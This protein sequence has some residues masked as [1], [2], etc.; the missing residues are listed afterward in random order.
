MKSWIYSAP[1]VGAVVA[2]ILATTGGSGG[3][4][5]RK[6]SGRAPAKPLTEKEVRTYINFVRGRDLIM[7]PSVQGGR[8]RAKTKAEIV[9][10]M[11]R[12]HAR[13]ELTESQSTAMVRRVGHAVR[14]VRWERTDNTVKQNL[15]NQRDVW[16][17]KTPHDE[18]EK[19]KI[20]EELARID[21]AL[22]GPQTSAAN[23]KLVLKFW[24]D[25]DKVATR[26]FG[27]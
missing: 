10:A 24:S 17:S 16:T 8:V 12:L 6:R 20:E 26:N 9:P 11:R 3:G 14:A 15:R 23:K 22:K 4:G 21:Q 18:Q 1:G 7:Q 5:D 19:R 13:L 27:E 25:L 2:I